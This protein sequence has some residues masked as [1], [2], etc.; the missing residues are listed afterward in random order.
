MSKCFEDFSNSL[1]PRNE[2]EAETAFEVAVHAVNRIGSLAVDGL[3]Y[4]QRAILLDEIAHNT[5]AQSR[6]RQY[7]IEQAAL[8]VEDTGT[9]NASVILKRRLNIIESVI[10]RT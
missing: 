4:R 10:P 1:E 9:A 2:S 7:A 5:P 8:W 6:S 3:T